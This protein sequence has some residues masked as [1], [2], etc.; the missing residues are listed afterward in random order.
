MSYAL[1]RSVT[2]DHTQ[3]GGSNQTDFTMLFSGTYTWLKTAANGGDLQNASGYD[4]AWFSDLALTTPLKFEKV[5][6]VLTT[7]EIIEWVKVPSVS[8]SVDTVIYL[9][10]KDVAVVTSQADAA[11]AW[12]AST[13]TVWHTEDGTT[14]SG[15]DSTSNANTASLQGTPTA[16][17]GKVGG[18]AS[19]NGS[20]QWL[21]GGAAGATAH[22][23][24]MS[25][26]AKMSALSGGQ[27]LVT[28]CNSGSDNS[29]FRIVLSGN[30]MYGDILGTNYN[31]ITG[32]TSLSTGVWYRF[33]MVF[34]DTTHREIFINGVSEGS[35]SGGTASTP[36]G[37]DR[38][39]AGVLDRPSI[40]EY[41][42]GLIDEVV[43]ATVAR[44]AAW[45]L[46]EYNSQSSPSTFYS[47]ALVVGGVTGTGSMAVAMPTLAGPT[48]SVSI[49]SLFGWPMYADPT[50][51]YTP[52]F[53][54]GS[55]SASYP[56]ANIQ[57]RRLHI[58]AQSSDATL[59]NTQFETDL[60][61]ARA[62]GCLALPKHNFSSAALMRWRGSN[63]AGS[64]GSPI[65]DSGWVAAWPAG[66]TVEKAYG[67]NP[68]A[69]HIPSTAQTA[70]YWLCEI[71]D[72]ANVAG[73]VS[74]GR[75]VI[76]G[77]WRPANG[78][79]LGGSLGI[80]TATA[81][82]VSDGGVSFFETYPIRRFWSFTL[83]Q[84][85]P[86]EGVGS[87]WK[88]QRQLGNT[89]QLFFVF[90]SADSLM[91]ERAFLCT[92]RAGSGLNFLANARNT[93]TFELVEEL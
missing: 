81:R 73:Y 63:A 89:G 50:V 42:T 41:L 15:A 10:Y 82:T 87:A 57:D 36:T 79:S 20:S 71:N 85:H 8:S 45:L 92:L 56:L 2:I 75:V 68:A 4:H 19:F 34:T 27:T 1:K 48:A 5:R 14:L 74:L 59:A 67:L 39:A 17:T 43:V 22:P 40:V 23:I 38:L 25:A 26:W 29:W 44:S 83:D 16:A 53:S 62:V 69:V 54:G 80:E 93:S 3:V 28:L 12:D 11:N 51:S 31:G 9:G 70:R 88:L 60:K 49:G 90:D 30:K 64:F 55:W 91:Y 13:A 37:I 76:A 7:G 66:V 52:T 84:M 21:R 24:T 46:A 77:A 61:V 65:Y 6:H 33:S 86:T 72:T 58:A 78:L 35:T 32:T 47:V 18:G